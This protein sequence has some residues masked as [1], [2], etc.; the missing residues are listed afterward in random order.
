MQI[1]G[2]DGPVAVDTSHIYQGELLNVP[3]SHVFGSVIDG[4]FEGRILTGRESYYVENAKHY[5]PNSTHRDES[6][7]HSVIY[8]ESHVSDPYDDIRQGKTFSISLLQSG[9]IIDICERNFF[10]LHRIF[11]A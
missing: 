3:K 11:Y 7:F 5:F 10:C 4:V 2:S 8:K 6:G 9:N 1:D